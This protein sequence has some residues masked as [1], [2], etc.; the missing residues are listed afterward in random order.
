[1]AI[2]TTSP[3]TRR[4]LLT[5]V[6]GGAAAAAAASVAKVNP[7]AAA[8]GD[9]VIIGQ[10]N[11]GTSETRITT[12]N[13]TAIHGDSDGHARV[14]G[15][16][17]GGAATGVGVWGTAMNPDGY[18]FG[19]YGR[20]RLFNICGVATI[21]KGKKSVTVKSGEHIN[22]KTFVLLTPKTNIGSR[23]L[24]YTTNTS[25]DSITIRMSSARG[26]P[27]RIAWLTMEWRK[28]AR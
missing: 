1:M 6:V 2:D 7:V 25:K 28:A 12:P 13:A 27:T 15:I 9:N 20:W 21:K 10:N 18:A 19:T 24:W 11:Q 23:A 3:R 26:G 5:A 22:G 16:T 4:A 8:N 17:H 14:V